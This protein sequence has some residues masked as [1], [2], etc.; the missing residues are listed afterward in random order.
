[1]KARAW[2]NRFGLDRLDFAAVGIV[3]LVTAPFEIP[4]RDMLVIQGGAILA[5]VG[6]RSMLE[7]ARAEDTDDRNALVAAVGVLRMRPGDV[8]LLEVPRADVTE[9]ALCRLH[10]QVTSLLPSG[11]KA[12]VLIGGI[13]AKRLTSEE[14]DALEGIDAT[15]GRG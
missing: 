1:V 13:T 7:R 15:G 5:W 9:E 3:I 2:L 12:M 14:A 6:L 11:V 10:A 8:F 4:L